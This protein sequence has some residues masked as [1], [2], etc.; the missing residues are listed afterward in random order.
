MGLHR[1][2]QLLVQCIFSKTFCGRWDVVEPAMASV[3]DIYN[4]IHLSAAG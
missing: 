2:P 3:A 1:L 4:L